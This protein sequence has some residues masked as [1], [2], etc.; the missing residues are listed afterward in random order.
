MCSTT[1]VVAANLTL[2]FTPDDRGYDKFN[3]SAIRFMPD[4]GF[5]KIRDDELF[6]CRAMG[7]MWHF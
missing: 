5:S 3:R 2:L 6:G 7:R 1:A 4:F